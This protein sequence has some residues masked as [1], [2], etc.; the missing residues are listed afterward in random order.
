MRGIKPVRRSSGKPLQ[1][2]A[3]QDR[4][5]QSSQMTLK[6]GKENIRDEARVAQELLAEIQQ[7]RKSK[8]VAEE[9]LGFFLENFDS[10]ADAAP[11]MVKC[12]YGALDALISLAEQLQETVEPALWKDTVLHSTHAMS[13]QLQQLKVLTDKLPISKRQLERMKGSL[14]R[15]LRS[16]A[17]FE[18]SMGLPLWRVVKRRLVR[19][20]AMR[21]S[22]SLG[23]WQLHARELKFLR[24]FSGKAA[25]MKVERW[26]AVIAAQAVAVFF[27]LWHSVTKARALQWSKVDTEV[28]TP[29]EGKRD[30]VSG[31]LKSANT[32]ASAAVLSQRR[33]MTIC[34]KGVQARCIL[35]W[36]VK[37][38]STRTVSSCSQCHAEQPRAVRAS[39]H[40]LDQDAR[41]EAGEWIGTRIDH[42]VGQSSTMLN[43]ALQMQPE[44][45]IQVGQEAVT[46]RVVH[47]QVPCQVLNMQSRMNKVHDQVKSNLL[48]SKFDASV[49]QEWLPT[50]AWKIPGTNKTNETI[51]HLQ[52]SLKSQLDAL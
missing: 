4:L 22:E 50:K 2:C 25:A 5:R 14:R 30:E 37:Y 11:E 15:Q 45:E 39:S 19:C 12:Q 18:L 33:L 17:E 16:R 23:K 51:K 3:V 7:L 20:A 1:H 13:N 6:T 31:W 26:M 47:A 36:Q 46:Q 9:E 42:L 32:A 52:A 10:L 43:T 29:L 34:S 35:R 41:A 38:L 28:H 8:Q 49:A 24:Q 21:M 44:L 48:M 27:T 40:Q